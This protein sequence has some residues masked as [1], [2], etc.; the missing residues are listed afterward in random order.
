M[1]V[2][3]FIKVFKI[4][5]RNISPKDAADY[6]YQNYLS[7]DLQSMCKHV[8]HSFSDLSS[9]LIRRFGDPTRLLDDRKKQVKA[10]P[11]P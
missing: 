6:L 8:R 11:F 10:L 5:T 3:E 7:A 2:F 9:L 1:N 4:I